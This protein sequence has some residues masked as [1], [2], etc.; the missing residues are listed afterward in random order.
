[1]LIIFT[2]QVQPLDSD[3]FF[4][5]LDAPLQRSI[6][7]VAVGMS[8]RS[9]SSRCAIMP[10]DRPPLSP[11][12]GSLCIVVGYA[13]NAKKLRESDAASAISCPSSSN[14][15]DHRHSSPAAAA[16]KEKSAT[17]MWSGGGLAD[18]VSNSST[19]FSRQ[20][21]IKFIA[22]DYSLPPERHPCYDVLI[23][24]LTEDII[25]VDSSSGN[26]N[27]AASACKL[28]SIQDYTA[29]NSKCIIVDPIDSVR[30]VTS[31]LSTYRSIDAI[32]LKHIDG[33]S[34][35]VPLRQP[36]YLHV[37]AS[38]TIGEWE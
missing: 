4:A 21:N 30:I 6:H 28:R 7:E 19:M 35:L 15:A 3:G 8:N 22:F 38:A 5:P 1:M 9:S 10:A 33:G 23:H 20:Q 24:K 29:Y 36:E 31:R 16:S 27:A 32:R 11:I 14:Y 37:P 25:A 17:T 26:D 2:I 18:I 34:A 12:A 13:L